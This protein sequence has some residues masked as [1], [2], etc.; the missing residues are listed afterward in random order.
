MDGPIIRKNHSKIGVL[1]Y[2]VTRTHERKKAMYLDI[3]DG[4]ICIFRKTLDSNSLDNQ[5]VESVFQFDRKI[6]NLLIDCA[7]LLGS[8]DI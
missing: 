1:G 2:T 6:Y 3:L 7:Y 8:V 4:L 5:D